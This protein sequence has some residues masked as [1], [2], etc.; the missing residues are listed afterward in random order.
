MKVHK[1][2]IVWLKLLSKTIFYFAIFSVLFIFS[3]LLANV[4]LTAKNIALF[5]S[6]NYEPKGVYDALALI[7]VFFLELSPLMAFVELSMLSDEEICEKKAS[8]LEN[9][10]IVIGCGHL[11]ERII[12]ILEDM[13]RD[14]ALIVLPE[15]K[16]KNEFIRQLL[17]KRKPVVF[18]DATVPEVLLKANIKKARSLIV[19]VNN[20]HDNLAIGK[21][22]K[23][24]NPRIKV[25][26]RIFDEDI[27]ELAMKAGIADEV[28]STTKVAVKNYIIGAY[29]NIAPFKLSPITIEIS[30]GSPLKGK[31]VRDVEKFGVKIAIIIRGEEYIKPSLDDELREGDYVLILG[32]VKS[33]GKLLKSLEI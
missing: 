32:D 30:K 8:A 14:Y 9:H 24:L 16:E 18:G 21:I 15:D 4:P 13:S 31:K 1:I 3:L 6:L 5:L 26:L 17:R 29:L 2:I 27:A 10:I 23:N 33:F 19:T 12:K 20:D 7:I 28:L 25:V 22:A 11:G